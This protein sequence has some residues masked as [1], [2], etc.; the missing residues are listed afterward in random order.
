MKRVEK[1][2]VTD[3]VYTMTQA[4]SVNTIAQIG[5]GK[6]LLLYDA[7]GLSYS[8]SNVAKRDEVFTQIVG[9]SNVKWQVVG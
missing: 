7:D 1:V 6:D 8:A 4:A 9:Y 5:S 3:L 2:S